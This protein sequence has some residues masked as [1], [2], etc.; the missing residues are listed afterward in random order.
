M[1]TDRFKAVVDA[2]GQLPP[3]TQNRIAAAVE[4]VLRQTA[5]P[6]PPMSPDVR[7]EYERV[8]PDLAATFAYLKDK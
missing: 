2:V 4:E 8:L 3:D 1:M 7:V 5:Q 6:V